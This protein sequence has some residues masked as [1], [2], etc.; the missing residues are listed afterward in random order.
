[1]NERGY[2]VKEL[3]QPAGIGLS[4]DEMAATFTLTDVTV[5]YE[6]KD[7]QFVDPPANGHFVAFHFEVT[8]GEPAVMEEVLW[9]RS[10]G[11]TE[12]DLQVLDSDGKRVNDI[13]GNAW[14]CADSTA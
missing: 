1:E 2:L 14:M 4:E 9:D 8:T 5:D 6:C 11:I 12:W 3:G 13:S 10:F 7:S